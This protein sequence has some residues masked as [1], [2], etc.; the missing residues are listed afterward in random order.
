MKTFYRSLNTN[1]RYG[2][3]LSLIS[4]IALFAFWLFY[5][6]PPYIAIPLNT[7]SSNQLTVVIRGDTAY[8][9]AK[10][11]E[12]KT[13]NIEEEKSA[14][15]TPPYRLSAKF[16]GYEYRVFSADANYELVLLPYEKYRYQS[17]SCQKLILISERFLHRGRYINGGIKCNEAS[18]RWKRENLVYNLEGV[19]QSEFIADLYTPGFDLNETELR[20]GL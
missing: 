8:L 4:L 13:L 6:P 7:L 11:P 10:R 9:V 20:I 18:D 1:E 5:K 2:L 16:G 19:S 3:L 15:S 12:K 17:I 14:N